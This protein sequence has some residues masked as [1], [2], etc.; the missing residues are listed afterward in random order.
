MAEYVDAGGVCRVCA[1][2]TEAGASPACQLHLVSPAYG[3]TQSCA[4]QRASFDAG[5]PFHAVLHGVPRP[6]WMNSDHY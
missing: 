5:N 4:L 2:A 6:W 1:V 3:P